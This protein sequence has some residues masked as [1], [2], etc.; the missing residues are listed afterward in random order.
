MKK[1]TAIVLILLVNL[2]VQAQKTIINSTV[3]SVLES[4]GE[5]LGDEADIQEIIDDLEGF[6]NNPLE[7]NTATR[8][9]LLRLHLLSESQVDQIIGYRTKTGVILSIYELASLEEFTPELLQKL[10]PC[11]AFENEQKVEGRKKPT[12]DLLVRGSESWSEPEILDKKKYFGS[13]EKYYLRMKA[14]YGKLTYGFVAEKDPGET[15]FKVPN[16]HGFDYSGGFVNLKLKTPE[17]VLYAGDFHVRFGQGLVAWQGFSMGKSSEPSKIFKSAQGIRSYSSTDENLFFRGG[18]GQFKF[19]KFSF[20]PFISWRKLDANVD[21]VNGST[22]FGAFQTSGYHRFGSELTGKNALKQFVS[23]G[24]LTLSQGKWSFGLSGVFNRFD[25]PIQRSGELYDQFLP[26]GRDHLSAGFDWKGTFRNI[27]IFGEAAVSQN[28]GK[29][30]LSGLLVKPAPNIEMAIV[31]RNINRYFFSYFSNTFT[32]SSK[33]NDEHGYYVGIKFSPLPRL[34]V[35]SYV[36]LFRYRWIK[37]Q[38]AAPSSGVEMFGQVSYQLSPNQLVYIRYF[39]EDKFE[40]VSVFSMKH[41]EER[42]VQKFRINFSQEVNQKLKLTSR[43][44]FSG[45]S[46]INHE[47]G[48]LLFQDF[49]Y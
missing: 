43:L 11:L 16:K 15:F 47:I 41:N 48:F 34:A 21:T 22:Y 31:Y 20:Y 36:D 49:N 30:V 26:N 4:R 19:R 28:S 35:W 7:L 2:W 29:A 10:E 45:Y 33:T 18:A 32:E 6:A 40:K 44:E 38:T 14:S 23:G 42:I 24:Y 25:I 17:N 1:V 27:F 5:N 46:R 3:E 39:Q 12:M 8:D 9:D 13:A 37:Y